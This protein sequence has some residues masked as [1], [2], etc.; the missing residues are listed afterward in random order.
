MMAEPSLGIRE[1]EI[2]ALDASGSFRGTVKLALTAE[3]WVF[4]CLRSPWAAAETGITTPTGNP[5]ANRPEKMRVR[6]RALFIV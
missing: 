3:V 1:D 2:K 6:N 4:C 5:I